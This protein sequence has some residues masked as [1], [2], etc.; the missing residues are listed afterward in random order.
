M[1]RRERREWPPRTDPAW[2][3]VREDATFLREKIY[4]ADMKDEIHRPYEAG[5]PSDKALVPVLPY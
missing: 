2:R 5:K 4:P 3:R 1:G